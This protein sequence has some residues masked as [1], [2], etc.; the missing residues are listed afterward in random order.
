MPKPKSPEREWQQKLIDDYY[1]YRWR[2]LLDP[3]YEEF[4]RWKEGERSH[5]EM[6]RAIHATHKE[7]QKL[8]G[9]F[10]GKRDW[11]SRAIQMDEDWFSMWFRSNPK[12]TQ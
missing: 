10:S 11:L 3:L 6:N 5:D 7:T 9:L 12:P 4:V 2:Q 8:Y 1:D